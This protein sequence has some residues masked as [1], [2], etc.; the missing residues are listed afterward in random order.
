MHNPN[1]PIMRMVL[2]LTVNQAH[3][4]PQRRKLLHPDDYQ[5]K[6]PKPY[7][8]F[9]W[10]NVPGWPHCHIMQ[11]CRCSISS[12]CCHWISARRWA[13]FLCGA[14]L[15]F[16]AVLGCISAQR[17]HGTSVQH[18]C[19]ICAAAPPPHADAA[20]VA[21]IPVRHCRCIISRRQRSKSQHRNFYT[22]LPPT[23]MTLHQKSR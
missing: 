23:T 2:L 4:R 10:L 7:I 9:W 21:K 15:I 1:F 17:C 22:L 13:A 8:P 3:A 16:C 19:S 11:W 14:G 18:C 12:W 5:V 6:F 20:L